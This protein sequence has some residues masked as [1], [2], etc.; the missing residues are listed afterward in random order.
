MKLTEARLNEE[1]A[2]LNEKL[3]TAKL[4]L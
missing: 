1:I 3:K 2:T 4:D